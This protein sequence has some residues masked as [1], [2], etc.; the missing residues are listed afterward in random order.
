M[1]IY[2]FFHPHHNPRLVNTALRQQEMSELEQA[3]S[4]LRKA[5][6]RAQQRT[7]RRTIAPIMPQHFDD[8][9]KAMSFVE[10]SLQ[11]L[12]DAHPGDAPEDL[13]V[14]LG[15]RADCAGWESWSALV[16]EQL[17][18]MPRPGNEEED[19]DKAMAG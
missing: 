10:R 13:V 16:R 9:L 19:D 8:I 3:A 12:C 4:E 1:E 17:S 11:T 18:T 15:E 6:V 7:Q 5:L 2:R 14:L